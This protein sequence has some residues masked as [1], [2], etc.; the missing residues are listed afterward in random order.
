MSATVERLCKAL[1]DATPRSNAG[2]S[3]E[4]RAIGVTEQVA[5]IVAAR[6]ADPIILVTPDES[7][8]RSVARDAELFGAE[9]TTIPANPG[10]PY[11][12]LSGDAFGLGSRLAALYQLTAAT[13]AVVTLSLESLRRRVIPREELEKLCR[14]IAVGDE[15]NRDELAAYLVSAGYRRIPVVDD[16]GSFAIRGDI[17]DLFPPLSKF[18]VRIELF[19]DEVESLRRFAPETQ[20]TLRPETELA[21]HPCREVIAT[22][23]SNLR[24]RL[25]DAADAA[26]HPS[27][28][29]RKLFESLASGEE[30]VGI[31]IFTPAFHDHLDPVWTYFPPSARLIVIDPDEINQ[32]SKDGDIEA[33]E[34]FQA[35]LDDHKIAFP[36]SEHYV[37]GED[38][39]GFVASIPSLLCPRLELKRSSGPTPLR[40][41]CRSVA[42]LARALLAARKSASPAR[43]LLEAIEEWQKDDWRVVVTSA[44]ETRANRIAGLLAECG[45]EVN[46]PLP[47]LEADNEARMFHL[48]L[49][50]GELSSGFALPADGL[51]FLTDDDL[52]GT[53][54]AVSSN[55]KRAAARARKALLGAVGDFSQLK[56]EDFLVHQVHGVGQ[57][58]GLA[59]LPVQ[60]AEIDFLNVEYR[61][62]TLYLPVFRI[63]EVQRYVG[64]EGHKPR[65]DK[66]GGSSWAKT[67]TRVRRDVAALAEALLQ[68]YAQRAALPG[69]A[70]PPADAMFRDFEAT[71]PF[72]ETPDQQKAIESVLA[73]MELPK[74]MDRLV[75][76]DVGYGKTEVAIR[77]MLKASLGGAQSAV[78]APTTVL[79]EQHYRNMLKRFADWPL[80]IAKLSRFQKRAAQLE[81]IKGLANGSI[82]AVVGTHRL[83]SKDVRFKELGLVVIDEEQRFGVVHKERLKKLRT[84]IDVLTLT[85]TPIPRTL[86]LAMAGL[87]DLSIIATPPADRR[88]I[89][90]FVARAEDG[91]LREGIRRE[92]GRGGQIFFVVPR[93]E[94]PVSERSRGLEDWAKHLA[95]LV[96]DAKITTAHG[97]MPSDKLEA[98]MV[99]FVAGESDILVSTT[100]VESGL[101]IAA[102]NTMFIADA[103]RFGLAQLYQLRGRIGRSS[104]RAYCFLLIPPAHGI[105]S[106]AKRRLETLQRFTDLGAGFMIASQDLEIRGAGELLGSKQSGFIAAVGFDAYTTM[107]EEAVAELRG[108]PIT[109]V[110]DPELN[111]EV[112]GYIPDDYVPD[113][114]Q[115]LTLYKRLSAAADGEEIS[116][117]LE[118]IVDRY[119]P[120]PGEVLL[121]AELMGL[122]ALGRDL[123]ATSID[124]ASG[125]L[126]VGIGENTPLSPTAIAKLVASEPNYRLTPDSRIRVTFDEL[127]SNEPTAAA[128]RSLLRL[129]ACVG[130]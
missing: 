12:E 24:Q 74:P 13:P 108:Q 103:D 88:S 53:R 21:I 113:T 46:R 26:A 92:L 112:P 54:R 45:Y 27:K 89:R 31:E 49:V 99:E 122:V 85:A 17:I 63:G 79:V 115:R 33:T 102:A 109:R 124:L 69:R 2:A 8:A 60:G 34:R 71:F 73:D 106:D 66:L 32:R 39:D 59:K 68:L 111:V 95:K 25:Y 105:T 51:V 65:I 52:F 104:V 18:P 20:R 5:A 50:A 110:T 40:I 119:G 114:G 62:G 48:S 16:P 6:S 128:K 98:A 118:E 47:P 121:L 3:R 94:A 64:A 75:C 101:D 37:S 96:P 117:L 1:A 72:E 30:F 70:F 41:E 29:T 61:G 100:I 7:S 81:T 107:L 126:T 78:L 23:G 130:S 91:V 55:Q 4:L 58:K 76:G 87:R 43:P 9:A 120:V 11:A 10:Q 90:T 83:L 67:Q 129:A 86:H 28:Q 77:A 84:Q 93:I 15:L 123:G 42:N 38:I 19:G 116:E 57:Y 44:S 35:R 127:E 22:S 82:D 56:V 36:P 14:S 125:R 80:R 97:Q